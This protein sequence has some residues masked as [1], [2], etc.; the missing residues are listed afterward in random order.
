MQCRKPDK[1]TYA[2][3]SSASAL[4]GLEQGPVGRGAKGSGAAGFRQVQSS[5]SFG[6][7]L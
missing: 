4:L 5:D 3:Y 6:I 2:T 7:Y 1:A